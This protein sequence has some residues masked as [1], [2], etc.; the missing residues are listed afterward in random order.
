MLLDLAEEFLI[1]VSPGE[2]GVSDCHEV[3]VISPVCLSLCL[4]FEACALVEDGGVCVFVWVELEDYLV[5]KLLLLFSQ[6]L[7][8]HNLDYSRVSVYLTLV[9][10]TW[11]KQG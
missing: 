8:A 3:L 4:V 10:D 11:L 1:L 7:I 6:V 2:L 9:L 5:E